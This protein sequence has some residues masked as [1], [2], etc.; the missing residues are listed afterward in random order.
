LCEDHQADLDQAD[1]Y[2]ALTGAM[3]ADLPA[4]GPEVGK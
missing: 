3:S 4:P 2:D 1:E